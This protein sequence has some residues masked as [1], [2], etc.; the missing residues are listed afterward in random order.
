MC[1]R[2]RETALSDNFVAIWCSTFLIY[3]NSCFFGGLKLTQTMMC[4]VCRVH[5]HSREAWI[6]NIW[7]NV[8]RSLEM[9]RSL[10]PFPWAQLTFQSSLL[11]PQTLRPSEP[12]F[13]TFLKPKGSQPKCSPNI[14]EQRNFMATRLPDEVIIGSTFWKIILDFYLFYV[15]DI[16]FFLWTAI[17]STILGDKVSMEKNIPPRR[18]P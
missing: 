16:G 9:S 4:L 8:E 17:I 2:N 6:V 10:T 15:N 12:S 11:C 14:Y 18:F 13:S 1:F 5:R 7:N 3:K